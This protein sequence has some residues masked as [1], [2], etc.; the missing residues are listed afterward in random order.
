MI[1]L[2]LIA[3]GLWLKPSA[4]GIGTHQQMGLPACTF[5]KMTG[6][7]CPSCGLTT[8]FAYAVRLEFG[9]SL[10]VQP[11]GFVFFWLMILW[12][13]VSIILTSKEM[14]WSEMIDGR[15][16]PTIFYMLMALYVTGWIWKLVTFEHN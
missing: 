5:L 13:P 3:I 16:A 10:S 11:F 8:S 15:W 6:Y 7:P 1:P 2:V 4:A 14:T 12:I 9:R